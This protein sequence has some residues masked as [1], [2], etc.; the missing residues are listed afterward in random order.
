MPN[1][2]ASGPIFT[3]YGTYVRV[4]ARGPHPAREKVFY[5]PWDDLDLLLEP[6]RRPQQ[7]GSPQIFYTHQYY[8][9]HNATVTHRAVG[10]F[11]SIFIGT[12]V[13]SIT[14]KLTFRYPSKMAKRKVD[15]ENRGFQTRWE[16]EYLFT[17]VAGK[18]VCLLCDVLFKF[19]KE[20]S[21]SHRYVLPNIDNV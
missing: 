8:I 19:I 3:V 4:K 17:E 15:T 2:D 20:N 5:G 9:S 10:C 11:I 6:A 7:A 13:V 21:C 14:V 1:R 16:S 12:A 18:P